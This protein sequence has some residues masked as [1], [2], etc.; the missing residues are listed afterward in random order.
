MNTVRRTLAA[1]KWIVWALAA[2]L[3]IG[4]LQLAAMLLPHNALHSLQSV[5]DKSNG[6]QELPQGAQKSRTTSSS[7]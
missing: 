3:L 4:V 5:E 7:R 6:I 2:L 1:R